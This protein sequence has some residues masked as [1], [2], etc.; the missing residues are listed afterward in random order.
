MLGI[1]HVQEIEGVTRFGMW[2]SGRAGAEMDIYVQRQYR[3]FPYAPQ[4]LSLN[5]ERNITLVHLSN[6]R[7]LHCHITVI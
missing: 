1:C 4:P 7:N 6:L 2:A 5:V 3:E